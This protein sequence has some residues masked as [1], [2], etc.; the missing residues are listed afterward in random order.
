VRADDGAGHIFSTLSKADGTYEIDVNG[1][2]S[3]TIT[4][5][6]EG[7][8][9]S[10]SSGPLAV[11][12]F[13]AVSQNMQLGPLSAHDAQWVGAVPGGGY[14]GTGSNVSCC[15]VVYRQSAM[16]NITAN[17]PVIERNG[18]AYQYYIGDKKWSTSQ[19]G[20]QVWQR[21]SDPYPAEGDMVLVEGTYTIDN[22]GNE[23]YISPSRAP[24]I[25]SSGNAIL[26]QP[27][28]FYANMHGNIKGLPVTCTAKVVVVDNPY[29][30][31]GVNP[32][33]ATRRSY[34]AV[35]V[36]YSATDATAHR[37]TIQIDTAAS[38]ACYMPAVG[39]TVVITGV[40][41]SVDD[42][43]GMDVAVDRY[44][45]PYDCIKV[46]RP[47]DIYPAE[48]SINDWGQI[49]GL[50]DGIQITYA[51]SA[52]SPAVVTWVDWSTFGSKFYLEDVN[53]TCGIKTIGGDTAQFFA[54]GVNQA[55][56]NVV[57][58]L[59]QDA[60]TGERTL[61][62][63]APAPYGEAFANPIPPYYVSN[64]Q[65]GGKTIGAYT[66]VTAGVGPA[67]VGLLMRTSG[68]VTQASG[69]TFYVSDGGY[70]VN[71]TAGAAAGIKLVSINGLPSQGQVVA[72]TGVLSTEK[73]PSGA[74]IPVLLVRDFATD[75][76]A[77]N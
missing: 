32:P 35:E 61:T 53:R 3:Y 9:D 64:R 49:R 2:V 71:D 22:G 67:N 5:V 31:P 63:I 36:P 58:K 26:N 23:G 16:G 54:Q 14:R 15:A 42:P 8:Y 73:S 55:L 48:I 34:L 1:G 43:W 69:T 60:T 47:T 38:V 39:Q 29:Y 40:L 77:A 33:T 75:V 66:G 17:P 70:C 72:V 57:G 76:Q 19:S 46:A 4:A 6:K 27:V 37:M 28:K 65:L 68:L 10:A 50:A 44:E 20:I 24:K 25:L 12:K 21:D 62:L 52:E 18:M 51:G 11:A 41:G 7:W 59:G 56:T 45:Y 13:T 30:S 74:I